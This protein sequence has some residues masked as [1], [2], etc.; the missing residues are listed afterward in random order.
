[1]TPFVRPRTVAK[2]VVRLIVFHHAAGSSSTYYGFNNWIP[3]D[4]DLLLCDLPGRGKRAAEP[5]SRRAA[6]PPSRR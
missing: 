3:D 4:W 1:M 5:P 2:P 6:E